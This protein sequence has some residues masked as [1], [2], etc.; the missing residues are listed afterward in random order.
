MET[1]GQKIEVKDR[2]FI[3]LDEWRY[4]LV[5]FSRM[6]TVSAQGI[7]SNPRTIEIEQTPPNSG[8]YILKANAPEYEAQYESLR[9]HCLSGR[10]P[11]L[12]EID[13]KDPKATQPPDWVLASDPDHKLRMQREKDMA[14][15]P[16][17]KRLMSSLG[18]LKETISARDKELAEL[19]AENDRLRE[20]ISKGGPGRKNVG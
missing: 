6:P 11:R 8:R 5:T 19:E 17:L 18:E 3:S 13:L 15:D 4:P 12:Q 16:E 14:S 20:Q 9:T 7:Q 1:A 10:K 2:L